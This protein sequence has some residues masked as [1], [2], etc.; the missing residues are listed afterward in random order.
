MGCI[1][2]RICCCKKRN[3][4]ESSKICDE[5]NKKIG[6]TGDSSWCNPIEWIKFTVGS[7]TFQKPRYRIIN[8]RVCLYDP[9]K[10]DPCII[11]TSHVSKFVLGYTIF[12]IFHLIFPSRQP[13]PPKFYTT[14]CSTPQNIRFASAAQSDT[15][16]PN[17]DDTDAVLKKKYN[18][19]IQAAWGEIALDFADPHRD[20]D[21][22]DYQSNA[23]TAR[24]YLE[25]K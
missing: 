6:W 13:G 20:S 19:N 9:S 16:W 15:Y 22:T 12:S 3:K 25:E 4:V 24:Q 11:M 21:V 17:P 7:S 10:E 8:G 23:M 2:S 18:L 1:L 14:P 5:L